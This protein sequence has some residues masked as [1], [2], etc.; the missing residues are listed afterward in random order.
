MVKI[1]DQQS[2]AMQEK[3]PKN[4]TAKELNEWLNKT[5]EK[6]FLIDVREDQEIALAPFPG[7]VLHLPLSKSS[8]WI[9]SLQ[10][11]LPTNEPIVVLC[12][13]GVRSW[14]FSIWLL[15]QGFIETVWNLEGGIDAWSV[16]IDSNVPRY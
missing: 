11:K 4:L 3:R 10:K 6:V 2:T 8:E 5:T 7:K 16:N 14:N 12:H 9:N 15:E 13:A 1:K